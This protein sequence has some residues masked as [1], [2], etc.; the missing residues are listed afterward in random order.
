MKT[1]NKAEKPEYSE[2]PGKIRKDG[3]ERFIG[4]YIS[5]LKIERGLSLN[6]I[7]SYYLDLMKFHAYVEREKL[8]FKALSPFFFQNFLSYLAELGLNAKTR[9]RFYSSIKGFYKFLFKRGI[10]S[11]FPFK[12][13]EYPFISKKLPNFLTK[14]EVGRILSVE[15]K[16]EG[17]RKKQKQRQDFENIRNKAAI[18]LL[19]SS[20]LRISELADIKL[21][22]FNFDMN[23]IRVRG[24][25]SKERIVP[26]GTPFKDI[27]KDYLPLRQKY[28]KQGGGNNLFIAEKGHPLTRQ[29]L[30]KIIKKAAVL[31]KVDKNIT[32]HM[33][34]HTFATHLLEG[35]ADLR[36]IQQMLGH[37]SISTTEIYTH[38]DI[39]HLKQ[40]HTKFHPRNASGGGMSGSNGNKN[41]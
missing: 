39:S 25:G 16:N 41:K 7:S 15:F 28:A 5:F 6:T 4:E 3:L 1:E 9:A 21:E 18:E 30:W 29:G 33:L 8:D 23:F 24:K 34:R 27:L 32:P 20:G 31:A 19:Y 22:N 38:T 13:I 17:V 26:F 40:Q 12:D 10:V 14:E 36:S 2:V 37:S 35:G 11:E